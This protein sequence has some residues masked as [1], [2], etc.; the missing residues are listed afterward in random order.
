MW[1]LIPR[2]RTVVVHVCFYCNLH[3]CTFSDFQ[4][5]TSSFLSLAGRI[6]AIDNRKVNS[7]TRIPS[8]KIMLSQKQVPAAAAAVLKAKVD[9]QEAAPAKTYSSTTSSSGNSSTSTGASPSSSLKQNLNTMSTSIAMVSAGVS[10]SAAA[11]SASGGRGHYHKSSSSSSAS[12]SAGSGY[13]NNNPVASQQNKNLKYNDRDNNNNTNN[14]KPFLTHYSSYLTASGVNRG[15]PSVSQD[16]AQQSKRR[17]NTSTNWN[18]NKKRF[19]HHQQ[20]QQS[21]L[22]GS[23]PTT[24]V[25]SPVPSTTTSVH[26]GDKEGALTKSDLSHGFPLLAASS[27]K[28]GTSASTDGSSVKH[29]N[30]SATVTQTPPVPPV[31]LVLLD[32]MSSPPPAIPKHTLAAQEALRRSP[33]NAESCE[34]K[35]FRKSRERSVSH[36][37]F[38][39]F[40]CCLY[41]PQNRDR[42]TGPKDRHM[43]RQQQWPPRL[44]TIPTSC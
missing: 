30:I 15:A 4:S 23:S 39:S 32:Q 16:Q 31:A 28:T 10:G 1:F 13:N 38:H 9:Q 12:A 2:K 35:S 33:P 29:N 3:T 11:A 19:N 17:N 18:T 6:D 14:G 20:Q 25:Q 21:Y 26:S 40:H 34:G 22:R 27:S 43:H 7:V 24:S 42:R 36:C 44:P 8:H 41:I 37:P 5:S